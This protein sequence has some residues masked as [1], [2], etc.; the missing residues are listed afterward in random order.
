LASER[1]ETNRSSKIPAVVAIVAI[2]V[3]SLYSAYT[4]NGVFTSNAVT[5]TVQFTLGTAERNIEYCN[6]QTLDLYIPT[7]SSSTIR[8][9]PLVIYVHGGGM[10]SGDKT[11]LNPV[12]LNALAATGYAVASI[13]Y[14]LAPQYKF[15]AQ[16]EDV[17]CAIRY[18]RANAQ[19]YGV[20]ASEILAFGTSAGG[21][22]V[23]IAAL[24]GS[25]SLFDV[26]AYA[27]QSSSIK[28]AVDMFGPANVT[29]CGCYST[30]QEVFGS[31]AN[32]I[33]ASPTHYVAANAPPL[34]IIQGM[35]DTTVSE[36]QSVELYNQLR[37]VGDQTQLVLVQNMGHMFAQV[38]PQPIDPSLVQIA[39]EMV[40]FFGNYT[41][42]AGG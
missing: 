24:T 17:K 41:Q 1:I 25:S 13:N 36:S 32:V 11:D 6:S 12:F 34:L 42:G 27:N 33:L 18:L 37:D 4:I 23:A 15:P 5:T 40:S 30:P 8:L 35:N 39:Q 28:A 31:Q 9:L 20:N 21:Q 29:S 7:G 10:A 16:I 3:I 2:L 38:G 19:T 14:R 26:G 22:L